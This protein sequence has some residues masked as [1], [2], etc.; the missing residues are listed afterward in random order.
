MQVSFPLR[1]R[2][3]F[4]GAGILL[5]VFLHNRKLC[6]DTRFA[7]PNKNCAGKKRFRLSF[8]VADDTTGIVLAVGNGTG[9]I[10]AWPFVIG[11]LTTRSPRAR[12]PAFWRLV[13]GGWLG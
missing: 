9:S 10:G 13:F 6:T 2:Q 7:V 1:G 5:S 3:V 4:R 8:R 11:D 12:L